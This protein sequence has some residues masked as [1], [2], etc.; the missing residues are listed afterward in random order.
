MRWFAA[1]GAIILLT[2]LFGLATP[3]ADTD[4]EVDPQALERTRTQVKMLDDLYKGYVVQITA[5]YVD[6]KD[7]MAAGRVTKAVFKSMADKGWHSARLVDGSG[8]PIN[9]ANLPKT[10]FERTAIEQMKD[11]KAYF[12]Q[13][14]VADGKP[15]LR[16]ATI[17]PAVMKQCVICHTSKKEGELLGAIVY[18]IPIH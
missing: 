3:A 9:K 15:V 18:E 12:E 6:A 7:R 4:V 8:A 5:N 2:G 16:A 10:D 14:A 17:V 11:G 1:M 13:V